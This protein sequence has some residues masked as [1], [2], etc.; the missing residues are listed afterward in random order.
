M[1]VENSTPTSQ[2]S[3]LFSRAYWV[4]KSTIAWN[5]DVGDGSCFLFASK[6]AALSIVDDGVEDYRA[7]K[8]PSTLDAKTLLKCQLAVAT[9]NSD[10]KCIN[11][12]GL[13]LPGVLDD[14]FSYNGPLGALYSEESMSLHLWAPTAQA[15]CACIYRDLV[16]GNPLEIV[17]LEEVNGVC[18]TKG[19]KRREGCYYVYEVSVYHPSTLRIDKCHVNGPYARGLSSDGRRTF[20]VNLDSDTLKPEEWDNLANEKPDI[21]SNISI[22]EL[23]I[24][25]FSCFELLEMDEYG[26]DDTLVIDAIIG[27]VIDAI[28][29]LELLA[30][31]YFIVVLDYW[32]GD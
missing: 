24:R 27:L 7:F 14:L 19:P 32:L 1:S 5:V 29:G 11:A 18:S 2:D 28:I 9:F 30:G 31:F 4:S 13:Q 8:V 17:Q 22:Y 12:T 6:T 25:D 23:H 20:L 15:V 26:D 3:L 21:F 10:G 16:G